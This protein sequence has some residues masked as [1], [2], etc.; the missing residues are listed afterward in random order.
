M[1]KFWMVMRDDYNNYSK[2]RHESEESAKNEAERLCKKEGCRFLVLRVVAYVEP[3]N[4]PVSWQ[5][6]G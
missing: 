3:K 1:E 6:V 2:N 4:P 5:T